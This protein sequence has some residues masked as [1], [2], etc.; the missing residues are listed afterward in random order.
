[1]SGLKEDNG[2]TATQIKE[3]IELSKQ[4]GVDFNPRTGATCPICRTE[5][6]EVT[7]TMPWGGS[8][9]IRYHKCKCGWTFKSMEVST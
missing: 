4:K 1:M 8:L 2:L 9:R 5:R 3:F 7:R 6:A